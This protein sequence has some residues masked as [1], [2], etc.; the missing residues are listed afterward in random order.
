LTAKADGMVTTVLAAG[1]FDEVAIGSRM[2]WRGKVTDV[3]EHF[4]TSFKTALHIQPAR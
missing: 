4:A 3:I 2:F 1:P